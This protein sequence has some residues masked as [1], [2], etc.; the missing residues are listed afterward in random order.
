LEKNLIS[1]GFSVSTAKNREPLGNNVTDIKPTICHN[2]ILIIQWWA[3]SHDVKH[4]LLRLAVFSALTPIMGWAIMNLAE[5]FEKAWR[6]NNRRKKW[7]ASCGIFM[8][9][10]AIGGWFL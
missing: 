9:L 7:M 8:F 6:T 2:Q 4:Y 3:M 1:R 5:N 10:A